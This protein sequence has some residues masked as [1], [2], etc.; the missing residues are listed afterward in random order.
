MI[1]HLIAVF[2]MGLCAGGLMFLLRKLSR[3]RL[4][5]WLISVSAGA[6]MIGYLAYYDYSWFPFKSGQ[7]PRDASI[8]STQQNKSFFRPWSYFWPSTNAFTVFDG[9]SKRGEQNGETLVE[10]Y[11]YTFYK[12]P[13]ERAETHSYLMN[14]SLMER[15]IF[16][17]EKP[18][19]ALKLEKFDGS[20]EMYQRLCL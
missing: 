15:V 9:R 13:I 6:A 4:P 19:Q 7:M 1:W 12:D 8:I 14:C 3:N 16:D 2:I 11:L 10:Y 17:K 18:E 20:D 5:K